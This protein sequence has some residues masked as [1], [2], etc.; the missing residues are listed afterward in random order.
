MKKTL[1]AAVLG[2]G[3]MGRTQ[4]E[5]IKGCP[6]VARITGFDIAPQARR[7]AAQ[8][9]GIR[10]VETLGEVLEDR[11]VDLVYIATPNCTHAELAIAAMQAGKAVMCEKPMATTLA[12]CERM[13]A[14]HRRTGC[15]L[16]I[17]FECRYS[18]LYARMKEILDSGE[19]GQLKNVFCTYVVPG[20]PPG[21]KSHS[22]RLSKEQSGGLYCEKLCHYVDLPRWWT[23]SRIEKFFAASADRTLPHYQ[24]LD[25]TH[26][27]YRFENGVVSHLTFMNQPVHHPDKVEDIAS[28]REEGCRLFYTLVGTEGALEGNVFYRQLR[29]FHHPGKPGVKRNTMVRVETWQKEEDH[30]YF[31]NTR[32]Q[33][34]DIARRVAMGEPPFT[35]PEDSLQTMRFCF[36]VEEATGSWEVVWEVVTMG[37]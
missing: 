3:G 7:R 25:N 21:D 23:G 13:V 1:H 37:A 27:T 24:V 29:V 20:V 30:I 15:F 14:V 32:E 17:G 34:R 9:Y 22:W 5:N 33:N 6:Y 35:P 11:S 36:A 16:Q 28:Q 4:I 26:L 8:S 19:I 31:H 12:D 10:V 2:L 18:R